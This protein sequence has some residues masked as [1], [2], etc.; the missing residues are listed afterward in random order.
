MNARSLICLLDGLRADESTDLFTLLGSVAP[1]HLPKVT[2]IP[3]CSQLEQECCTHVTGDNGLCVGIDWAL[4][5]LAPVI[6]VCRNLRI[7]HRAWRH[8]EPC[9]RR[10]PPSAPT[11]GHTRAR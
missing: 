9:P 4:Y 10:R 8:W 5:L 6:V 11:S 7:D 2:L 1:E 3:L